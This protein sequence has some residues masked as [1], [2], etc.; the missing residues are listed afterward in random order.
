MAHPILDEYAVHL[1]IPV[2]WGSM[3]AFQHVNNTVYF[4]YFEDVRLRYFGEVGISSYM[5]EHGIGPILASTDCRFLFPLTYPDTVSVGTR[6]S[7]IGDDRFVMEYVV[8]SET[9]EC[10][11]AK[12]SGLIVSFDYAQKKKVVL[13]DEWRERILA[14]DGDVPLMEPKSMKRQGE[15]T[16]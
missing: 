9:H 15:S 6:V 11:A 8:W 10:M 3:D 5:E 2:T 16:K 12:G 4:R 14:I 1:T 7:A 13:P